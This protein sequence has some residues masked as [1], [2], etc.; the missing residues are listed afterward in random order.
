MESSY[1]GQNNGYRIGWGR[2]FLTT[3]WKNFSMPSYLHRRF[4]AENAKRIK[5]SGE[6]LR[7]PEPRGVQGLLPILQK[8]SGLRPSR[9][10][11]TKALLFVPG[12]SRDKQNECL[13]ALGVFA[14]RQYYFFLGTGF[15][16][17]GGAV[18]GSAILGSTFFNL[19]RGRR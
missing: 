7:R 10:S 17:G 9:D 8:S 5:I 2:H 6:S 11:Q 15:F 18:L 19:A 12:S 3:R 13:C 1:E 4:T 16:S 14:V